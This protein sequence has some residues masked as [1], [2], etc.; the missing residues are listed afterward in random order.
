M[1][2]AIAVV[3]TIISPI[4]FFF[5]RRRQKKKGPP[6][7]KGVPTYEPAS[8]TEL[9][10][11]ERSELASTG[12]SELEQQGGYKGTIRQYYDPVMTPPPRVELSTTANVP[13]L[14]TS[15]NVRQEMPG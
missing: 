4:C 1:G 7:I 12:L 6:S 5:Y 9:A 8:G 14:M 13:E 11:T 10:A 2:I 3:F 15:A